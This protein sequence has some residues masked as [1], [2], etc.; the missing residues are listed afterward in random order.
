MMVSMFLSTYVPIFPG[1]R[2]TKQKAKDN[3]NGK[4]KA[5][6]YNIVKDNFSTA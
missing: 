3:G 1:Q 6:H 5:E 2:L 4:A